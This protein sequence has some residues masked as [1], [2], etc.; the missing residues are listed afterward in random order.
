MAKYEWT[1]P[2]GAKVT[3]EVREAGEQYMAETYADGDKVEVMTTRKR[4]E[5]AGFTVNGAAYTGSLTDAQVQF[6]VGNQRAAVILPTEVADAIWAPAHKMADEANAAYVNSHIER[7][8]FERDMAD[9][10]FGRK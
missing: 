9:G 4:P 3:L 6:W 1:T 10:R 5:V 2:K 7:R 8:S